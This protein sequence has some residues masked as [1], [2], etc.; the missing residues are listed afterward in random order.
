MAGDGISGV[1]NAPFGETNAARSGFRINN[2]F[3]LMEFFLKS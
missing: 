3:E 1:L 2:G